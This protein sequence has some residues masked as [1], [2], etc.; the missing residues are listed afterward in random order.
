VKP[1]KERKESYNTSPQKFHKSLKKTG[2]G[3][4]EIPPNVFLEEKAHTGRFLNF[5]LP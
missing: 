1:E 3:Q 4:S 2:Y 5:L